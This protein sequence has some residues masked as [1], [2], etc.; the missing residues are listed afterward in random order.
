MQPERIKGILILTAMWLFASC[1]GPASQTERQKPPTTQNSTAEHPLSYPE[2]RRQDLVETL[3]GVEVADPYRWL[4]DVEDPEVVAWMDA[5]DDLTRRY[6]GGI[7]EREALVRRF[8]ELY[9]I[10]SMSAPVRRGDRFFYTRRHADKEKRV[11]YWRAGLDGPENVLLDPN[12]MSQDGTLSIGFAR[13][14]WDGT[15]VAYSVKENNADEATLYVMDVE[16]GAV[17]DI[18]VIDGIKYGVPS[19]TP[20]GDGFYYVYLPTDS[21]IP[22]AERPGWAEV[23]YHALGDDPADDPLI[24]EKTGDPTIFT[25]VSLSR[26]GRFLFASNWHGWN[27]SDIYYRDLEAGDEEFQPLI[28]GQDALYQVTAHEGMFYVL[29]N[30]GASRFRVFKVDPAKPDRAQWQEMI[31]ELEDGSVIESMQFVG[32]RLAVVLTRDV[33]SGLKL[34]D[35]EGRLVRDIQL[36]GPGASFGMTGN[37]EDDTA[38]FSFQSPT[39]PLR[40]YET[41]ISTG[42]TRVWAEVEVPVDPEP[43][44]VEQVFY[45]SKDGTRVP[46]YI[47]RRKDM[48]RDGSTPFI[49]NGYGGF[50]VTM[51]PYFRAS[52]YPWLEAGGGFAVANLR[53]GAEYGEA[54]HRDG[55]LDKK[56]N[57]FDD[58]I[59]AAEYLVDE[60]Y[61]RPEKLGIRGGSNGGLLVGAAMAQRPDLFGA[62]VC[63]VPLLDMVR[64]HKFGS[65]KT[66]MREYGDPDKA[67]DFEYLYAYSPYHR[68]TEGEAYPPFLMLSADS[69]DRVDPMHARKFVAALQY[70]SGSGEPV[71]L[72]LERN[73]GHGGADLVQ[74]F[75]EADADTYAF[76][77]KVLMRP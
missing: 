37:P 50:S 40:I 76:L 42:T 77:I 30:E 62:V 14:S 67:E 25:G 65:G 4:E 52:I 5:Q 15:R 34:Y 41:Q 66:W 27:A 24:R 47:V 23:R 18:D 20:E 1:A 9:Y 49:L 3:H 43:F 22:V 7:D 63:A 54:W 61:T 19:W 55:M 44:E 2:T 17:S 46:M 68:L 35:L 64:F 38:Y 26:D 59:A 51:H 32:G 57:V 74:S 11:Y 29:T 33:F 8:K 69:D 39:T 28:E 70:A 75:V 71:L 10:D 45:E 6:L 48:P 60:G 36:P 16:T 72:R 73:A 56:Q 13:P 31:P 58:F 12:E 21:S 53:G